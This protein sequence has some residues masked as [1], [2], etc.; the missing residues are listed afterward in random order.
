MC[1]QAVWSISSALY[2]CRTIFFTLVKKKKKKKEH[3]K[4][5]TEKRTVMLN[6]TLSKL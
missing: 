6:A 3:K 1:A 5:K 2:S 4:P